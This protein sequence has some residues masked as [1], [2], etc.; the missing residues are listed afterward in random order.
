MVILTHCYDYIFVEQQSYQ[1]LTAN[2]KTEWI[3][4]T[5]L[6]AS[7]KYQFGKSTQSTYNEAGMEFIFMFFVLASEKSRRNKLGSCIN[8]HSYLEFELT[9]Y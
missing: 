7:T 6:S 9:K 4:K 5:I 1:I 2:T 3:L 8:Y